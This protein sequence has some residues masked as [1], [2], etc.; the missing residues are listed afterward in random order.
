[1]ASW[2]RNWLHWSPR[3]FSSNPIPPRFG[4]SE[5]GRKPFSTISSRSLLSSAQKYV[6]RSA[7]N[8]PR[9]KN[10]FHC[11]VP[12]GASHV[13][14]SGQKS[15]HVSGAIESATRS[16]GSPVR[17]TIRLEAKPGLGSKVHA[18]ELLPGSALMPRLP[19]P[20]VDTTWTTGVPSSL[21][22]PGISAATSG[23]TSP[24]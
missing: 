17:S 19:G 12:S 4:R 6:S 5:S 21:N 22:T 11:A 18:F 16:F 7:L 14:S 3:T 9:P 23:S 1:M 2:A 20:R 13:G 8:W 15:G 24:T 10:P